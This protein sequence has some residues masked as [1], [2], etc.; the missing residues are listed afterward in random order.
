MSIFI[1]PEL[2]VILFFLFC[3]FDIKCGG[4][5][6]NDCQG[7][8]DSDD[9]SVQDRTYGALEKQLAEGNFI[10]EGKLIE[11]NLSIYIL[12]SFYYILLYFILY[13]NIYVYFSWKE[14]NNRLMMESILK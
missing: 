7:M 10:V 8:T 1:F 2:F 5:I 4:Q 6:W 9:S 13:L 12:L 11:Q 3:L 14:R